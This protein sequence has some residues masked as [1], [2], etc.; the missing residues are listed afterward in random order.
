MKVSLINLPDLHSLDPK[1]D[2]PLGL[3]YISSY[4]KSK[5]ID[6]QVLDLSFKKKIEWDYNFRSDAFGITI[7][8]ATLPLA[9]KFAKMLKW[10]Y[11]YSK[12][13]AGGPHPTAKPVSVY[14]SYFFDYVIMGEG[15]EM[16]YQINMIYKH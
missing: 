7:N 15:E 3:M 13:V 8:S 9:I 4:L 1:L 16:M 11:P 5:G 12:I 6:A 10:V 2:A 14:K